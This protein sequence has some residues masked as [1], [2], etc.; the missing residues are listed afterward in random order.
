MR[1][2]IC[3]FIGIDWTVK[4]S[5]S[6][7]DFNRSVANLLLL[8]G[9]DIDRGQTDMFSDPFLYTKWMPR[10]ATLAVWT[11]PRSFASYEKSCA[12]LSNNQ[13]VVGSLETITHKAWQMFSAR[14]YLH[15]YERHGF[16][17]DCL[18]EL[19]GRK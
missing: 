3:C 17:S 1:L 19:N 6:S 11:H 4:A 2:C 8:R 18:R 5:R 16:S 14:A 10:D 12:L 7:V 13:S 9:N 15:H